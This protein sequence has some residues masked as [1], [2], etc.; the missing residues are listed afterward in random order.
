[1]EEMVVSGKAIDQRLLR[2]GSPVHRCIRFS[3]RHRRYGSLSSFRAAETAVTAAEGS[4]VGRGDRLAR[5]GIGDFA[6]RVDE[7]AAPGRSEEHTSELQSLTRI[8]YAVFCL[9]KKKNTN[10]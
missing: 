4:R 9:N 10:K 1:M 6:L 8:S 7:R 2:N 3:L 5:P